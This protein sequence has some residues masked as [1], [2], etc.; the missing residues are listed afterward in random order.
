MIESEKTEQAGYDGS[1]SEAQCLLHAGPQMVITHQDSPGA[2]ENKDI[3]KGPYGVVEAADKD[4]AVG[5]VGSKVMSYYVCPVK[6]KP[7]C[8]EIMFSAR[9]NVG[10]ESPMLVTYIERSS[11]PACNNQASGQS[12]DLLV[13]EMQVNRTTS[14]AT[15][16]SK[17]TT[18]PPGSMVLVVSFQRP[19]ILPHPS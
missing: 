9:P 17:T 5:D 8:Y 11:M 14:S 3:R 2:P 12:L 18:P 15:N 6:D 10:M 1:T 7:T 16:P 19:F 13:I 4:V